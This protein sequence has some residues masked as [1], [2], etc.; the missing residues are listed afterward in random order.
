[1]LQQILTD[2]LRGEGGVVVIDGPV[3]CGRTALLNEFADLAE[4]G[5]A[6]VLRATGNPTER[7]FPLSL[8]KQLLYPVFLPA[9]VPQ[10]VLR[11]FDTAERRIAG[12]AKSGGPDLTVDP[13][14]IADLCKIL[15]QSAERAP[16]LIAADDIH[17][18]DVQSIQVLLLLAQRARTSRVTLVLTETN[19]SRVVGT[20]PQG[21]LRPGPNAHRIHLGP[22]SESGA[23]EMLEQHMGPAEAENLLPE[24]LELSG[25]NPLLLHALLDDH[26]AAGSEWESAPAIPGSVYAKGMLSCTARMDAT[27]LQVLSGL[28]VLGDEA[29][30]ELLGN[31]LGGPREQLRQALRQL[32]SAGLLRDG[33]F[34]H[35]A[36]R[37][38]ILSGLSATEVHALHLRAAT[39]LY[40]QGAGAVEVA[41]HLLEAG[42][43]DLAWAVPVLEEAARHAALTKRLK[44]AIDCLELAF[45]HCPDPARRSDIKATLAELAWGMNPSAAMRHTAQLTSATEV[46]GLNVKCALSKLRCQLWQ[47]HFED[48]LETLG[49]L[50]AHASETTEQDAAE[51]ATAEAWLAIIHPA[52]LAQARPP[53]AGTEP[54][55]APASDMDIRLQAGNAL[56]TLLNRGPGPELVN[57]AEEV[58]QRCALISTSRATLQSMSLALLILL[59]SERVGIADR[60]CDKL[61]SGPDLALTPTWHAHMC[62]VRAGISLRQGDLTAVREWALRSTSVLSEECWGV[63]VGLPRA[64][65][66]Q[67]CT[68]MGRHQEATEQLRLAVPETMFDTIY[69]PYYLYARG[70]HNLVIGQHHAALCDFRACGNL[71]QSWGVDL[72]G[73]VLWRAGAAQ[74]W[75]GIGRR[76]RARELLKEQYSRLDEGPSRSRG[77]TL[78][79]LA[80]VEEPARRQ[81]MLHD[82]SEILDH[83]GDKL[84]MAHALSDLSETRQALGDYRRAQMMAHRAWLTAKECSAAALCERLHPTRTEPTADGTASDAEAGNPADRLSEAE[85]RVAKLAARGM[86]N[87]QISRKL[88]ITP[89]T[90]EQHLTRVYRKLE[91]KN[92]RSLPTSLC[93]D[94]DAAL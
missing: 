20:M 76:E 50:Y 93:A 26:R 65:L 27:Q 84:H 23:A 36:A 90:V 58:L 28:A 5:G 24:F 9:N 91:V 37:S 88:F 38:A 48:G 53:A 22:L 64:M 13:D 15:L 34:R 82:S 7:T 14:T 55:P 63:A 44:V 41:Q 51:L 4:S 25:G 86:T 70:H 18:A 47:G 85:R 73:L 1:M 78:W 49:Q 77:I 16:V 35:P 31:I 54:R 67:A 75:L 33:H 3:A 61:L 6:L 17:F 2:C 52:L 46:G 8:L 32:N 71:L 72:A 29:C 68:E 11:L 42:E 57:Q 21:E 19:H 66:I 87:E 79:L 39:H 81:T 74:A 89:S 69:G 30:P 12:L 45:R 56:I 92:R 43:T 60:W 59:Y 94:H 40:D 62:V 83:C 80:S 10:E